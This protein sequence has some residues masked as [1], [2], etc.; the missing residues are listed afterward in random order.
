MAVEAAHFFL[1]HRVV[2][3]ETELS[4]YLWMTAVAKLGHLV[5]ADLLVRSFMQLVAGEAAQIIEGMDAGMPLGQSRGRGCGMAF[6]T[7]E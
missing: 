7:D 3:E 5:T 1:A 6:E 2:G 4:L